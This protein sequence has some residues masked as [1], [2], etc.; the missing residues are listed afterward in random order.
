MDK[1]NTNKIRKIK[2]C[3][4]LL[5]ILVVI[6]IIA[7]IYIY[8]NDSN[9]EEI[10]KLRY[11]YNQEWNDEVFPKGMPEFIRNYEGELTAQNIGKSIYYVITDSIPMY[12][13]TLSDKSDEQLKEYFQN[14]KVGISVD[15]GIEN[16]LD[17]IRLIKEIEKIYS[18]EFELE[19]FYIDESSIIPTLTN[20]TADLYIKYKDC[21]EVK[22]K[23][24]VSSDKNN[25]M[26]SIKYYK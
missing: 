11:I 15:F 5:M 17:F 10:S 1:K 25:N 3:L 6:L 22:L 26:S 7:I 13:K 21:E 20:T 19:K 23:I 9:N 24:K 18:E 12:N 8:K 2:T 14:N 16:E 4:L